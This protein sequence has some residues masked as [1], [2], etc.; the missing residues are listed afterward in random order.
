MGLH[1]GCNNVTLFLM[2]RFSSS[3]NVVSHDWGNVPLSRTKALTTLLHVFCC[4]ALRVIMMVKVLLPSLILLLASLTGVCPSKTSQEYV[5][6]GEMVALFCHHDRGSS[7]GDAEVIWTSYTPQEMDLTHMSSAE[8]SQMG[9]LVYGRSLVILNASVNHQGNYSCSLGNGSRWSWFRLTVY[10]TQR[11]ERTQY[12]RTCSTQEACELNCPEVNVP[13]VNTPNITS[14]A[15]IWHKEG[16]S[17]PKDDHFSSV[18][19]KDHGVYICTRSY[20]YYRQIY[21]MTFTVVLK[22]KPKENP[23]KV[24]VITSPHNDVFYVDLGAPMV[25]DCEAVTD[26]DFGELF[27]YEKS[28]VQMNNSFPVFYNYTRV[29]NGAEIKIKASLVFKSVSQEDLS[30]SY[31]CKLESAF[32]PSSFVTITLAQKARPSYVS[33]ALCIVGVMVVMVLT[34]VIYVR[35]KINITLFLRDT[36]GYHSHTSDGKSYDAFLMCYKSDTE[37]GLNEHDRKCLESVLEERF[38]YSLCL[39]DRDVLPGKAAAEAV[40]ECI[41]QSRTVVLVPTSPDPG[42]GSGLLSAI[43]AALV[44]RQ[45]RLVFI[46]TETTEA[47]SSGS[48]PEALQLLSEAGDCVTWK[49]MRSMP[50]SSSFWKQLRYYLPA[51][52]Q[53]SKIKLLP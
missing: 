51:P 24:S 8:Q 40:L 5:K 3:P 53:A 1:C 35:F 22:I 45:T 37:A 31:T 14:N 41:E 43:H 48:V 25:I 49:G 52:Q 11:E 29:S 2:F 13:A 32:G 6:A 47:S 27:W 36:L 42:P 18:E 12:P 21:N 34:V 44:E 17:L 28:K 15:I 39:Y 50:L 38:G 7:H 33:L 4:A 30:K 16:E 10:T 19:E 9:L 20:L 23:E 26:P 46:Q